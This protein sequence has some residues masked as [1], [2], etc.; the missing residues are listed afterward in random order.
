MKSKLD[1]YTP[2]LKDAIDRAKQN[3]VYAIL[4]LQDQKNLGI[5]I[6]DGNTQ[7]KAISPM[8]GIGISVFTKDGSCAFAST[9][10]LEKKSVRD[11]VDLAANLAKSL[12]KYSQVKKNKEIFYV[13]PLTGE[14]MQPTEY[15]FDHK[16]IDEIEDIAKEF[17]KNTKSL[18][19][20]LSVNTSYANV[21]ETWRILRSD[22]TD[23]TFNM[24]RSRIVSSL[25]IKENN[26]M[27]SAHFNVAGIDLSVILNSD[28]KE[29]YYK[30]AKKISELISQLLNAGTIKGGNYKCLLSY[31][32]AGLNAH[33][34][35][36]HPFETD[37]LENSI[38]GVEGKLKKGQKVAPSNISFFDGPIEGKW[39]NQFI[40][41]NGIERKTIEFIKDG[42]TNDAISDVFSAKD[43]GVN[44]NGCGRAEFFS[45]KPICRMTATYMVDKNPY[46]LDKNHE[47]LT[48]DDIYEILVKNGELK[49]GRTIVYPVVGMGGQ[50]S[51]VEGTFV[52]NCAGIYTFENPKKITLYK[53]AL[54]SGDIL[55][56][57]ATKA[58][59]IG[60]VIISD[61]GVCGKMGQ[62]AP[63]SDG[64]NVFFVIDKTK[65]INFGGEQ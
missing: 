56:A 24:P 33:E 63:V 28:K 17:N 19:D 14:F 62:G 65:H 60:P 37:D 18:D 29:I 10:R 44:I 6:F 61:P 39:G 21:S 46:T 1:K 50:V 16:S 26:K 54:F 58:K 7:A 36:G 15:S 42:Y 27:S 9:S 25:S 64:G 49:K 13:E 4:R 5:S 11:S 35:V 38:I 59:G 23:V 41:A 31:S 20:R 32:F 45:K 34:A 40:S 2:L 53:Q 57:T 30:K 43:A 8:K 3:D 51:P 22:G 52:F 47:D 55:G 48:L 12:S